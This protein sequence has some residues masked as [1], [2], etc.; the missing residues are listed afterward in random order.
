[1]ALSRKALVNYKVRY[2]TEFG[3][4]GFYESTKLMW[5]NEFNNVSENT[6]DVWEKI[7]EDEETKKL[8]KRTYLHGQENE[9]KVTKLNVFVT[10]FTKLDLD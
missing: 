8:N 9:G 4:S 5:C 6:L 7:L 3:Y 1:M 10:S 2:N